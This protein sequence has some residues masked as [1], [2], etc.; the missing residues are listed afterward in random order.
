MRTLI[1]CD[2]DGTITE[3]DVSFLV[4]DAFANGNWR[5][6][7]ADYRDGKI[8][9]GHFNTTAFAMVKA[10]RQTLVEFVQHKAEIRAGFH[11]LLDYCQKN[12]FRFVIVS[13]GLDFYIDTI[14]RDIGVEN[15]EV[16]AA[17]TR[18]DPR[19]IEV[20]Y[21]GPD[22]SELQDAFKESYVRLF[23]KDGYRVIY[24]GD[25]VSDIRPA[26]LAHRVFARGN[27]LT[28][29]SETNLKCIPFADL[30]DVVRGLEF[31]RED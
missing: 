2:F 31:L 27:L 20:R 5:Q 3:K 11:E 16:F 29:C 30:N 25:G 13:N 12:E 15:I 10:D 22:G 23:L 14:L 24:L 17:Q 4:L 18:F 19:G 8:S 6:L 26:S 7:L 9:V 28:R 21:I 1:Q